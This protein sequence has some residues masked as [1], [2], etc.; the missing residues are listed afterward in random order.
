VIVKPRVYVTRQ[1]PREGMDLLARD[2]EVDFNPHDRDMTREELLDSVKNADGL[3]TLLNDNIDAEIMD[4]GP[5]LKVIANYAVGFNNIDIKAATERGIAVANTPGVLTETTADLA[6]AL[7]MAVA[8]RIVE[9]DK[10]MRSG[11]F[12][13]WAPMLYLG[14]DVHNKTLG[15]LGFGRIGRAVARR[16]SGFNM[17]VL[18]SGG[19]RASEEDE[20]TYNAV[21]CSLETLLRESDFISLHV[22]L[23]ESTRHLIGGEQF[24]MMKESAILINTAR[25]PVVDEKALVWALKERKIAG[26]GL[27][28]YEQE[29][30]FESELAEMDN[31]VMVPHIGS[32]SVSTRT[33]MAMMVASGAI[34]VLEGR[35]P[36]HLVNPEVWENRRT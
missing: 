33:K 31:V 35:M 10:F 7:L 32:A 6:W 5:R 12:R 26:A 2:C 4:A 13:G 1:L 22:P 28:V 3:V 23:T 24:D 34:D 8:R 20:R 16:A 9:S 17:R 19:K 36:A 18:Y 25:G 15:V 14:N 27:D 30:G 21:F 11:K 29:P